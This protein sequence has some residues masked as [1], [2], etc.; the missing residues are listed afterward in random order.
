MG[1]EERG[2]P[3]RKKGKKLNLEFQG[4]GGKRKWT[5][6]AGV[7]KKRERERE[8]RSVLEDERGRVGG[9]RQNW[10]QPSKGGD[11]KMRLC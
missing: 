4:S 2:R 5:K 1:I 10:G 11:Y 6:S 9:R 8:G 7:E 3:K